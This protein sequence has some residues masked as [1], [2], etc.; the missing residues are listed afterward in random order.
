MQKSILTWM[1]FS[2]DPKFLS[3]S[4]KLKMI[5]SNNN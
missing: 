2:Q 4:E 3:R 5:T 1:D